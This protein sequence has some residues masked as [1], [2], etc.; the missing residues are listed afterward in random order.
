MP[1]E[2]GVVSSNLTGRAI[3]PRSSPESWVTECT[4]DIQVYQRICAV[5]KGFDLI[6]VAVESVIA[7]N[8]RVTPDD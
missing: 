4:G 3:T 7:P 5:Y 1:P 6:I 8:D 2:H